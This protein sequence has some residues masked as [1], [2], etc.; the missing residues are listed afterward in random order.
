[1]ADDR[2]LTDDVPA[3]IP[4]RP[5]LVL[6]AEARRQLLEGGISRE[7]LAAAHILDVVYVDKDGVKWVDPPEPLPPT[8]EER[9]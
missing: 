8:E 6:A 9:G 1:M 4:P 5:G 3:P 7:Q 2:R